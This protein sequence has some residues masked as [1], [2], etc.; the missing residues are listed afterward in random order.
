[1]CSYSR[2]AGRVCA[3]PFSGGSWSPGGFGSVGRSSPSASP[4][5]ASVSASVSECSST[6][7]ASSSDSGLRS[8]RSSGRS[9][10][11]P[12]SRRPE[13]SPRE[14]RRGAGQTGRPLGR[15][16]GC[17]LR[18]LRQRP[19]RRADCR[20]HARGLVGHR[21]ARRRRCLRYRLVTPR[22]GEQIA[23]AERA[24]QLGVVLVG[25]R[26]VVDDVLDLGDLAAEEHQEVALARRGIERRHWIVDRL[27]ELPL[28]VLQLRATR[29]RHRMRTQDRFGQLNFRRPHLG[30][31]AAELALQGPDR[32]RGH[33]RLGGLDGRVRH[34]SP[35][36]RLSR[37]S[38]RGANSFGNVGRPAP[39]YSSWACE[40]AVSTLL[41]CPSS[42]PST[43]APFLGRQPNPQYGGLSAA[44]C[45]SRAEPRRSPDLP[46]RCGR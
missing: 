39:S 37:R 13:A 18:G 35:P 20:R 17:A 27:D 38:G 42:H 9:G 16:G 45:R 19:Q 10:W 43:S 46:W 4:S 30:V 5:S 6:S 34:S 14:R 15:S 12:R 26:A 2:R 11:P 3:G 21:R 29:H 1:M 25:E 28:D 40:S 8:A 24:G 44:I 36:L 23:A 7:V 41:T 33:A 22:G 31:V 32:V